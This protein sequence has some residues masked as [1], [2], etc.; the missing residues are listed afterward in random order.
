MKIGIYKL[1]DDA[2][3]NSEKDAKPRDYLGASILGEDCSRKI[4]YMLNYP[5]PVDDA[6]V[7]R[8]FKVG[9]ILEDYVVSLLE[10]A[11]LKVWTKDQNDEQFGFTH[12]KIA[13]HIDGVVQ[14]LPES[15][16]PHLLEIKTANNNR[17]NMFLK[18]GCKEEIKY[19]VQCQVYMYKMNLENCLFVVINKD[20]QELYFERIKLDKTYAQV[21][22]SRGEDIADAQEIPARKY[23]K[24][25]DYRCKFCNYSK[26]CW[27]G[28]D[29]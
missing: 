7:S 3:L 27:N 8:I 5:R 10:L 15:T 28:I 18:G 4:W 1:V 21:A 23:G 13:G 26:D 17:F 20:N 22:L 2:I 6:R 11:G 29:A 25:T 12:G 9:H 16:M 19:F 14:G 24:P